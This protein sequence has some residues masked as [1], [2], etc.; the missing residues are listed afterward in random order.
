[1]PPTPNGKRARATDSV[2]HVLVDDSAKGSSGLYTR[3][4]VDSLAFTSHPLASGPLSG[5][6]SSLFSCLQSAGAVKESSDEEDALWT[7][8]VKVFFETHGTPIGLL[9][10]DTLGHE[11]TAGSA[12]FYVMAGELVEIN[13]L[14]EESTY[15]TGA[16]INPDA[17]LL[18][19]GSR[20]TFKVPVSLAESFS[21]TRSPSPTG[22]SNSFTKGSLNKG[23]GSFN[24]SGR[25]RHA[26]SKPAGTSLIRLAY[27]DVMKAIDEAPK[28]TR[29]LFVA[30]A[31]GL[32]ERLERK[33]T[34]L[35]AA[36]RSIGSQARGGHGDALGED[37]HPVALHDRSC[38]DI[39][40]DFLL[41]PMP[42]D[43]QRVLLASST[44]HLSLE[45]HS[46]M[47]WR[48]VPASL[49]L[50]TS[51][52]CIERKVLLLFGVRKA[53]PIADVLGLM[54][55]RAGGSEALGESHP[56]HGAV[57]SVQ[58][59]SGSATISLPPKAFDQI[60]QEIEIARLAATDASNLKQEEEVTT[61]DSSSPWHA[62]K[63]SLSVARGSKASM[64]DLVKMAGRQSRRQVDV[65]EEDIA[66]FTTG[67]PAR[68]DNE[69]SG[70]T[71]RDWQILLS[72]GIYR[73]YE[74]G[75]KIVRAGRQPDGLLQLVRG[76]LRVE[77]P[78]KDRPQA[79]VVSHCSKVRAA[80]THSRPPVDAPTH[81][82]QP[83]ERRILLRGE[84]G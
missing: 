34:E 78:Q 7:K 81:P 18:G 14:G 80:A 3:A 9:P 65:G 10:G 35:R 50:T 17:F 69:T 11:L 84:G 2:F 79:L 61:L 31:A 33:A 83:V 36:V 5:V 49:Y 12:M 59:K 39:A 15:T 55:K 22:D 75:E 82:P 64:N 46:E 72:G 28:D 20:S 8:D 53:F 63:S 6:A 13:T 54:D 62:L 25:S 66:S 30:L 29:R 48:D 70:L 77:L 41:P 21:G 57:V 23:A 58:M 71:E 76:H 42:G 56:E 45:T 51:H 73:R 67:M 60:V 37:N 43:E 44:C 16:L 4:P 19:C 68:E 74:K 32:S 40:R 24:A 47:E 27:S 52:L 26:K 38:A 1:M